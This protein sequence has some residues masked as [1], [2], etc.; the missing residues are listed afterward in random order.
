M[1]G[2][3]IAG[4]VLGLTVGS[5]GYAATA[6]AVNFALSYVINRVFGAKPPSQQDNGVRQQIPP[7][8]DNS[9][10]VVYGEAWLGGTFVDAVMSTDNQ[11]MYYVLAIS[12]ISPNGQFTYD[13]TKFYYGDRLITFA[14][15]TNQVASLTDGAGNVDT[16][17]NGYLYINLYTSTAAGAI[18]PVLG[19]APSVAMGGSDITPAL[20][21]PATGRQMNGLAFAIVYMKYNTDAGT[22]GLQ[23]LT[24]KVKHALNNTGVAKPG[25]VLQDYLTNEVYGGAVKLANVDTAACAAL[26]AYSDQTITYIPAGGGSATQA[27]YRINGVIDTGESVLSNIEKIL[28]ACDSWIGY[29]AESG[30]WAP[31]I[32]KAEATGFAFD[33]T[34]IIGDIRVSATDITSSINEVELSFPWKENKDKPGYVYLSLWKPTPSPLLYPNEPIN[35]YTTTLSMVND[36]VQAQYLANRMLEQ[37]REDLIVSFNTAY[38]GIQVNAGD[39]VSVTNSAYGWTNKLFRVIKVNETSL[40]DGNLGARF[41]LSEYNAQVYDDANIT[42]FTPAPN[43]DLQSG[44]YFPPL[45]A[46]TFSDQAPSAQPP[47]FS[48]TCQ[49]PSTVRVT[50]L[51]LYYTTLTSPTT[52]DWKV[53]GTE[54]ASNNAAFSPGISIKFPNVNLAPATYYFA[55]NVENEVSVSQ[56]SATSVAFIWAPSAVVGPTGPTGTSGPT[57]STGPS[58]P[59]G[60]SGPTGTTGPTGTSGT[61]QAIAY[62]YQWSPTT[63]SNPSGTSTFTW[64]TGTNGSY[65][66]GGGWTTFI[67]SNPGTPGLYL[68]VASKAVTD[69]ATAT[70]TTVSW[71]SG[72]Q[73]VAASGNGIDGTKTA[74]PQVYQ[75]AVTIPAGP[76]GTSTYTWSTGSFTPVPSGW[77]TSITSSPSAGFTLWT[78]IVTLTDAATVSTSTINWTTASIVSAGYAG[79]NGTTGP[80]GGAGASAR[81]CY[82]KTTLSSLASSPST[83]TTTGSAS[84]PPNDSWGAGTVWQAT[85]P[86]IV[87]GESVYQSDGIYDPSTNQTVWNVPYLSA[88][89]VGTLSAITVNTG[90]L[91][92]QNTLTINS[93]GSIQGGQTGYNTGTGFFLGYSGAAYKFSIGDSSSSLLWDGSA[94]SLTGNSNLTIGG[95]ATFQGN[96][97]PSGASGFNPNTAVFVEQASSNQTGITVRMSRTAT[98]GC[99]ISIYTPPGGGPSSG[100]P[101]LAIQGNGDSR[102]ITVS[103][104]TDKAVEAITAFGAAVYGYSTSGSGTAW[105]GY[106]VT[107]NSVSRGIYTTGIQM[108]QANEFRWQNSAGTGIGAYMATDANDALYI[109]SGAAGSADPKAVLIGTKATARVRVEAAFLRPEVDNAVTL[110]AGAFRYVDV[111]AVSGSVNTSDEREKNILGDNP[112]GLD[113]INRLQTIQYKWKVAQAAIVNNIVDEEGNIIGQEEEVPAREGVR[114]FH[115]LSA[116]QV[117]TTLDAMGIDS[118]AGWVLTD[119]DDPNSTQGLRYSEFIAPLIK[120]VQELS[121]KV[122]DLE[123][124][125]K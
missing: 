120:A 39:V 28:T 123:A 125:L 5:I 29:Q 11:A 6:F 46:P 25:S 122:A 30:Q 56:L 4:T 81:I 91:T 119:K 97:T 32:N 41:E 31:I 63:P 115:G 116:Q 10:P 85:P 50:K 21:W 114:T 108:P 62:L 109:I 20:R 96:W 78:A 86:S 57:G 43:S 77:S 36:S 93:L 18:T 53:W 16:K 99:G 106:F 101:A 71:A 24:F 52:A 94:L 70:T 49:L 88:L 111:Y 80:T 59:S 69:T 44:Y 87:A 65:T 104:A 19:S 34:N 13:T 14:P 3:I 74:R 40:P 105:G 89:K 7:S 17:I 60:P 121:Q 113:F 9:I 35:K 92:V 61:Q 72:Y 33:D 22:T 117:K 103:V 110:G 124:K 38:P 37:A 90:A 102:G 2:T 79:N 1:V 66:G 51:T 82:T 47:T 12:N 8:A 84:F 64:A 76:T 83:I 95:T 98:N 55:F 118:F 58:G 26:D 100:G 42:A 68:W 27:R 67:P 45:S 23:P 73:V 112:L 48:V 15:G 107:T 54:A 75:W